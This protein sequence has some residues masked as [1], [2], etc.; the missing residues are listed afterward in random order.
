MTITLSDAEIPARNM[1]PSEGLRCWLCLCWVM[2]WYPSVDDIICANEIALDLTSD[3][4]PSRL[5]R[6][7]DSIQVLIDRVI[8]EEAKGLNYQ[9]ALLLWGLADLHAF[10]G[11]NHRTAYVSA[12]TFL[13][14]NG[15]RLRAY[16]KS[17]IL[18]V[19][20]RSF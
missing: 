7:R 15:K 10:D 4:H 11:G 18:D 6:S 9:A 3:K 2:V 14:K 19:F 13:F 16:P 5:R 8:S 20:I 12:K 17:Q 1:F